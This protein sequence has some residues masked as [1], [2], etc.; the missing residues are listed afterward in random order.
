MIA[1]PTAGVIICVVIVRVLLSGL[2]G[3]VGRI[4][5]EVG[6]SFSLGA[7]WIVAGGDIIS[8]RR[9]EIVASRVS[10]GLSTIWRIGGRVAIVG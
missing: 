8:R 4:V 9:W 6:W 2:S 1:I 3:V 5:I 10:G 7:I